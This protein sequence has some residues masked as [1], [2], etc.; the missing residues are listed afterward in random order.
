MRWL[1]CEVNSE[2][3]HHSFCFSAASMFLN[4][5]TPK[6]YVALT[7]TSSLIS[8]LILVSILCVVQHVILCNSAAWCCFVHWCCFTSVGCPVWNLAQVVSFFFWFP[9]SHQNMEP[10]GLAMSAG[11]YIEPCDTL[12]LHPHSVSWRSP[13]TLTRIQSFLN[14]WIK[15]V[16]SVHELILRSSPKKHIFD[17]LAFG[18]SDTS[19]WK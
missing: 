2:L 12:A 5:L 4:T 11:V 7:G 16:V 14:E 10:C 3:T 1:S 15:K 19:C 9:F 17:L 18:M 6:F 8:G 13:T